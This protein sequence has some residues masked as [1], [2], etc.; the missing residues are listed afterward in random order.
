MGKAPSCGL[1]FS[2]IVTGSDK[3]FNVCKLYTW[4]LNVCVYIYIPRVSIQDVFRLARPQDISLNEAT[5]K[6]ARQQ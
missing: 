1:G 2:N 4:N 3:C 6:L 5:Q